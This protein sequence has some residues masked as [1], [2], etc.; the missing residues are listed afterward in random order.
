MTVGNAILNGFWDILQVSVT[1]GVITKTVWNDA[2]VCVL[3]T[4]IFDKEELMRKD[5]N[6]VD[7]ASRVTRKS[8]DFFGSARFFPYFCDCISK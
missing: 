2:C 4:C 3:A 1:N 6:I 8:T 5:V 7:N